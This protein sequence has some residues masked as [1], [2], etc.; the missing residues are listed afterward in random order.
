MTPAIL[1]LSYDEKDKQNGRWVER[2]EARWVRTTRRFPSAPSKR[3]IRTTT[4]FMGFELII[5]VGTGE[6]LTLG[7]HLKH[8][9]DVWK[10]VAGDDNESPVHQALDIAGIEPRS[11]PF[12]LSFSILTHSVASLEIFPSC[13]G[14][15]DATAMADSRQSGRAFLIHSDEGSTEQHLRQRL[16]V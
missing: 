6:M 11:Q 8:V 4:L 1:P 16:L 13:Q 14:R 10:E 15:L 2:E 5:T 3:P 9:G 7:Q 12:I